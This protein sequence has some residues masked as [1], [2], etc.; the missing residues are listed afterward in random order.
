MKP[1]AA[2][3]ATPGSSKPNE[4]EIDMKATVN[5]LRMLLGCASLATVSWGMPTHAFA[6][7][8]G[9][10]PYASGPHALAVPARPSA[11]I[12]LGSGVIAP[13][14][15]DLHRQSIVGLWH[16]V[17]VAGGATAFESFEKWHA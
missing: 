14:N 16:T 2:E 10:T 6:A 15:D 11:A 9:R 8:C 13:S 4:E 3:S 5:S 7:S 17:Y 12:G 1:S